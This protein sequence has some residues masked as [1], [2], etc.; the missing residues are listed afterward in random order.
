M[1]EAYEQFSG[2]LAVG[3][4]GSADNGGS[5]VRMGDTPGRRGK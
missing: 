2:L 4:R 5:A 3:Q 1:V